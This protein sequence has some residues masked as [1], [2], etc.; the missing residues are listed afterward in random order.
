MGS[1][2]FLKENSN[3]FSSIY[4][5]IDLVIICTALFCSTY[6]YGVGFSNSY[7][8]VTLAG[9]MMFLYIAELFGVYRSWRIGH[10]SQML[11]SVLA[12]WV[13]TFLFITFL[14][15]AFKNSETFSRVTFAIWL[16]TS[17]ILMALWFL[18]VFRP[19]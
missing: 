16:A 3:T 14:T 11:G 6:F 5:L 9:C 12:A 10:L 8:I 7:V 2:G 13:L 17:S 4:R 18:F 19:H 1:R 15:F